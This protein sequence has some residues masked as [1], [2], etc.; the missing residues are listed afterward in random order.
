M[1]EDN[2]LTGE[3]IIKTSFV[4]PTACGTAN[5][6]PRVVGGKVTEANEYPWLVSLSYRG[7]LYCGAA[8]VNDRY[9]IS[10][11]HCIKRSVSGS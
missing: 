1:M 2:I 9:L 3:N 10:A 6:G 5:R 11:A 8:L 7:K 4:C